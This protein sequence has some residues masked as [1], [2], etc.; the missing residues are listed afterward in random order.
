MTDRPLEPPSRKAA[1]TQRLLGLAVMAAAI[2]LL[3]RLV[4]EVG[5]H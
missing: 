2:Y 3:N 1:W 5:W 4:A